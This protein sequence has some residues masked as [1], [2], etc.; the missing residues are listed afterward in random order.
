MTIKPP[1]THWQPD[2][3]DVLPDKPLRKPGEA[4]TRYGKV[5]EEIVTELLGLS[6]IR[7]SGTHDIVFDAHHKPSDTF[8]EIKSLRAKNKLPVYEWRRT[9]DRDCGV[10]LVYVIGVHQCTKQATLGD[11]WRRMAETLDT[12]LVLP[13]WVVDLEARKHPLRRILGETKGATRQGYS[14]KGYCDGYR[15]VPHAA[16]AERCA[17]GF[18]RVSF[19]EVHGLQVWA[20]I[21]FHPSIKP[22]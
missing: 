4:R 19:G 3:L 11:V 16:L 6:D 12:V 8:C 7:N 22:W 18:S 5:V 13:A 21:H 17:G 1:S 20:N 9:K 15:N 10:P 14:R 2:L